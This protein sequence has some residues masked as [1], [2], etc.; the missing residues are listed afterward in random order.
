MSR[1][2]AAILLAAFAAIS[3]PVNTL[4]AGPT[5]PHL[6][7]GSRYQLIFVTQDSI[8]GRSGTEAPY[9]ALVTL[10]AAPINS[11]LASAGNF[12]VSWS[13]I[14]STLD[15]STASGNA[16]WGGCPVYNLQAIQVNQPT[17]SLYSGT[18]LNPIRFDPLGH[19]NIP[20][21][22]T[23][24][25]DDGLPAADPLGSSTAING[26]PYLDSGWLN[27]HP[28]D[29][30]TYELYPV[31]GLSSVITIPTPEPATLSLL[32]TGIVLLSGIRLLRRRR[33]ACPYHRRAA[34]SRA[35]HGR[36]IG[37]VEDGVV[38]TASRTLRALARSGTAF[39]GATARSAAK[40]KR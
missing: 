4:M 24:F 14:T 21:V 7:A 31:Y 25:E 28:L 8:A 38:H 5:L 6:A 16:P 36:A 19:N 20:V 22:W 15:G 18:L 33:R 34:R 10:D 40:P 11:L 13:A 1:F 27:N 30:P 39:R 32:G 37:A 17:L 12:G 23:G 26:A 2:I 3:F 29:A 9:N 35:A